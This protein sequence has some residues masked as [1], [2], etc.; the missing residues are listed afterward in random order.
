MTSAPGQ[1][2]TE[3]GP[4]GKWGRQAGV[5]AAPSC[6]LTHRSCHQWGEGWQELPSPRRGT[7]L[8]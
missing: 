3:V 8:C 5:E 6:C 7:D 1:G 2:P 4:S